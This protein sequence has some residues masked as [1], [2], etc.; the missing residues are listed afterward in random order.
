MIHQVGLGL[1][2]MICLPRVEQR[3]SMHNSCRFISSSF[4]VS[5]NRLASC[6]TGNPDISTQTG[7]DMSRGNDDQLL[8]SFANIWR[9][10]KMCVPR[11]VKDPFR[12]GTAFW[13]NCLRFLR[14]IVRKTRFGATAGILHSFWSIVWR[15]AV[16]VGR[17]V[18]WT[19]RN[20]FASASL[21]L[22][23]INSFWKNRWLLYWC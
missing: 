16:T 17:H 13:R 11:N 8:C 5:C 10:V 3:E 4:V 14:Q 2:P 9:V 21:A 23:E 1:P 12:W 18:F 15:W 19:P 22:P 7:H 6:H 20:D